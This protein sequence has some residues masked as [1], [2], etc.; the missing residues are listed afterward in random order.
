VLV[1]SQAFVADCLETTVEVGE[2]FEE[3]FL[4]QGGEK[5]TLVPSL[6]DEDSWV[7]CLEKLSKNG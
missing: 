4:E 5:W 1:F 6:N 7:Q 3:Q 2:T